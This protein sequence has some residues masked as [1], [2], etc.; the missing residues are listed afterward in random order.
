MQW[1]LIHILK[2]QNN[3]KEKFVR[4]WGKIVNITMNAVT[5]TFARK[6][7]EKFVGK[8]ADKVNS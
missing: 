6:I 4:E 2:V 7:G 5:T 1:L 3:L 8:N